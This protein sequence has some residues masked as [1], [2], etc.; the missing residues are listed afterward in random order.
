MELYSARQDANI[1]HTGA[2]VGTNS[3]ISAARMIV[4][5]KATAKRN[6]SPDVQ[7][8]ACVLILAG[9]KSECEPRCGKA[10]SNGA[11]ICKWMLIDVLK[12]QLNYG[13][14]ARQ[15]RKSIEDAS[16]RVS[17]R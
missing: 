9:A 10:Y 11:C 3:A 8:A 17:R 16:L 12:P 2:L 6:V 7:S 14:D 4:I 5:A 13:D 15:R 1:F